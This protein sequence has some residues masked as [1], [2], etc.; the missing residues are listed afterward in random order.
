MRR[1]SEVPPAHP[2]RVLPLLGSVINRRSSFAR[3]LFLPILPIRNILRI[4]LSSEVCEVVHVTANL[5]MS[6][7]C[8]HDNSLCNIELKQWKKLQL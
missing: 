1:I 2:H 4:Q 8:R 6:K 3:G 7:V 5:S